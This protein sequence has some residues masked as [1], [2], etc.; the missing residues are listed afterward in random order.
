MAAEIPFIKLDIDDFLTSPVVQNMSNTAIGIYML[1]LMK[2]WRDESLP[3]DE[4]QLRMISRSMAFGWDEFAPFLDDVF[5]VSEDGLR[6]NPRMAADREQIVKTQEERSK[7][8]QKGAKGRWEKEQK[9]SAADVPKEP[10]EP[11]RMPEQCP[12]MPT[13]AQ[14]MPVNAHEMPNDAQ[15]MPEQCSSMPGD[16]KNKEEEYTEGKPS[17]GDPPLSAFA[18]VEIV[19]QKVCED[20][21]WDPPLPKD[22]RRHL[23]A[24]SA[25]RQMVALFGP[26]RSAEIFCFAIREWQGRVSWESVFDKRNLLIQAM[27]GSS[28]GP[29]RDNGRPVS[30]SESRRRLLGVA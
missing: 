27:S 21:G 28:P 23:K 30:T 12:P 6:R 4:R 26:E 10:A 14:T 2:Q 5:P 22:V 25:L 20:Q 1:L 24:D 9:G 18:E 3:N 11:A 19:L 13:D 15:A 16:A 8:G 7:H 17:D 29:S